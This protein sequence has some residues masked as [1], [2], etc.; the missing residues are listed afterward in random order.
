[1]S[2]T[3]MD[4]GLPPVSK[5]QSPDF[6]DPGAC[7]AWLAGL[8]LT[9][10]SLAQTRLLRQLSLLNR[11]PLR[12]D[13]RLRILELLLEPIDFIQDQCL[14]RYAGRPLPFNAPEQAAFDSS[15]ALWQELVTGWLQCL[16]GEPGGAADAPPSP[17]LL[18]SVAATRALEAMATIYLDACQANFLTAPIFWRRLHMI[19]R[20]AEEMKVSQLPVDSGVGHGTTAASAYAEVLLLAAAIPL[21]LRPKQLRLV[22]EW[23]QRWANKVAILNK[24]PDDPR[25]PP[26]C[27]DLDSDQTAT[28]RHLQHQLA[29][30]DALR[31][32]DLSGV[33]KSIKKRLVLLAQGET[34]QALHL[35]KGCEQPACEALLQRTYQCWCKGGLK[36]NPAKAWL[37]QRGKPICH[38]VSGLEA[39]HYCLTGQSSVK[40]DRSIYRRNRQH[41]EIATFGHVTTHGAE[42]SGESPGFVLEEWRIVDQDAGALHLERPLTP[43]GKPLAANQLVAVRMHDGE[44]FM[45]GRLSWIAMSASRDGLIARLLLFPGRPEGIS[46]RGSGPGAGSVQDCRGLFLPEVDQLGEKASM[47][48]PSGWFTANRL[49]SVEVQAKDLH[50]VRLAHLVERGADFERVDFEWL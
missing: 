6:T 33:R 37:G 31:W 10:I 22:A 47:L 29:Q 16:G 2:P 24:P 9:N 25:T 39:I 42:A 8:P 18:A 20:A 4:F 35:G 30:G 26:L 12:A 27:V 46:L 15:Q 34:P 19:F 38:L 23:A 41:D 49:L 1:M 32:L 44:G 11:Y 14:Q 28:F 17:H 36:Q 13:Q 7:K 43:P 50:P 3:V 5:E 48:L 21:E 45:L 40:Q